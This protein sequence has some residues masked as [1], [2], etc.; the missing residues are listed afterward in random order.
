ML[1][2]ALTRKVKAAFVWSQVL[3]LCITYHHNLCF[4]Q[5][6]N[7]EWEISR[8][9]LPHALHAVLAGLVKSG[10]VCVVNAYSDKD[11]G[12]QGERER[13]GRDATG[14]KFA[15]KA[16]LTTLSCTHICF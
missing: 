8:H 10:H 7:G 12:I 13:Y 5:V 1:D 14:I 2:F 15:G 9:H 16:Y 11:S 3:F 4:I 6:I